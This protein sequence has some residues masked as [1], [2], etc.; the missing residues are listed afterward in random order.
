MTPSGHLTLFESADLNSYDI[1]PKPLG[2]R[3]M[4][5]TDLAHVADILAALGI[6]GS[7]IFVAFEIRHNTKAVKASALQ[8]NTEHWLNYFSVVADP[9]FSSTF[10]KGSV[11]QQP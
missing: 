2:G 4:T 11:G 9:K 3:G 1:H 10:A 7:M 8:S 5:L 6:V